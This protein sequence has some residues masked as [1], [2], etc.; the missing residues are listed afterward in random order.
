[1]PLLHNEVVV[2]QGSYKA[3]GFVAVWFQAQNPDLTTLWDSFEMLQ[4]VLF[5][6]LFPKGENHS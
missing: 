2:T 4:P 3:Y 5:T 6:G 1:M